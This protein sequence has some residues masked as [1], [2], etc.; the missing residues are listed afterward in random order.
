MRDCWLGM[1]QRLPLGVTDC[2]PPRHVGGSDSAARLFLRHAELSIRDG[3]LTRSQDNDAPPE[4]PPKKKRGRPRLYLDSGR[5]IPRAAEMR[6]STLGTAST[7]LDGNATPALA[8]GKARL[9]APTTPT[10]SDAER[11]QVR[12][13]NRAAATRYRN[14]MSAAAEALEAQ[15]EELSGQRVSLSA[16]AGQLRNEIY[17]LKSQ[18]FVHSNCN[19]PLIN[20]Y[21]AQA[22]QQVH[23]SLPSTGRAA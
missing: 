1:A 17:E 13:R 10:K 14:K 18:V 2:P 8:S 21:L 12:S 23:T 6:T 16:S 20:G 19:D 22:A 11:E 5:R 7:R 9:S 15:M 3:N 4:E